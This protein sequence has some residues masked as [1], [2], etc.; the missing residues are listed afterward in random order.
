MAQEACSNLGG[1]HRKFKPHLLMVLAQVAFT[2]LYFLTEAS[3]NHGMNPHVYITYRHIVSGL[4]M[5]PF[6]YV[7]ERKQRPKLTIALFLE[8]FVLSLLGV[9]LTLNMY[10]V[11]MVYYAGFSPHSTILHLLRCTQL[12]QMFNYV[13][14]KIEFLI[15]VMGDAAVFTVC[16]EHRRAAWAIGFNIDLWSILYSVE[17]C[18]PVL[19]S[20]W[21]TEKKGPVFL[22]IFDPVSTV[23]V[24]L[25]AYFLLGERLYTGSI[26]GAFS[27]ILGLYLLLWGREGDEVYIK[28]E[29]HKDKNIQKI[30]S[31]KT[32]VLHDE[33]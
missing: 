9:G 23:F 12:L 4:V 13:R 7:L 10:M 2:F 22:A 16:I 19:K 14:L 24:A 3:F 5:F 30:T 1:V 6:A 17:L 26:V 25:L 27:V 18:D 15:I 20:S 8:L 33:P 31:A 11:Y 21:C 29:E 32:D 28:S